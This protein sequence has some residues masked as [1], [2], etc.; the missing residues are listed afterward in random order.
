MDI[1]KI[2]LLAAG[3]L[4]VI[5]LPIG[6]STWICGPKNYYR[7]EEREEREDREKESG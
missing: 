2:I 5:F 1:D 3:A 7:R 6:F 4:L